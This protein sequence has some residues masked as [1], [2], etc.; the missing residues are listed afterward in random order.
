MSITLFIPQRYLSLLAITAGLLSSSGCTIQH[1]LD[2]ADKLQGEAGIGYHAKLH[3]QRQFT[4]PAN[5]HI[6][7]SYV[8]TQAQL[9]ENFQ[10][11]GSVSQ[12]L[13]PLF[14][15]VRILKKPQS[16]RAALQQARLTNAQ[17]LIV[18]ELLDK[19]MSLDRKAAKKQA[20]WHKELYRDSSDIK[21][22]LYDCHSERLL[23]LAVVHARSGWVSGRAPYPDILDRAIGLYTKNLSAR[24]LVH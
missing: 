2:S 24:R 21:L 9:P 13:Q 7:V 15:S 18:A 4:L 5:S 16:L 3:R 20:Y 17:F 22:N 6:A 12:Q 19:D 1:T 23:D 14:A 10:L 11:A 8:P